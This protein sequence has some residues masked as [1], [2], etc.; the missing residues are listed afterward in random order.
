[1]PHGYHASYYENDT[2]AAHPTAGE[3]P[4]EGI[5][6]EDLSAP[7]A[8]NV[9]A[10]V[11]HP[12]YQRSTARLAVAHP[13]AARVGLVVSRRSETRTVRLPPHVRVRDREQVDF[14]EATDYMLSSSNTHLQ[15]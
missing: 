9:G 5:P 15:E 12:G 3:P 11:V 1:M 7:I 8:P 2:A 13:A 4:G 10:E 6:L 14:E